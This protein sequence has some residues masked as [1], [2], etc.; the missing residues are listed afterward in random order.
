MYFFTLLLI[1]LTTVITTTTAAS[2]SSTSLTSILI[3]LYIYPTPKAWDS[4]YHVITA[5]PTQPFTII[6]NP[7]SGP[8]STR[9]PDE[10]YTE[11][12]LKLKKFKNVRLI[13]YVHVSY[14][15]RKVQDVWKDI[16][17]YVGWDA[18]KKGAI[19]LD[20]IFVDE[21]PEDVGT[22]DVKLKYMQMVRKRVLNGFRGIGKSG[23][24]M[25]NPGVIADRRF[26]G[27]TAD[28]VISF[29]DRLVNY[30]APGKLLTSKDMNKSPGAPSKMQAI[31]VTSVTVFAEEAG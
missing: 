30:Y 19:S 4:L 14:T 12:I 26:Y 10:S 8:G 23:F 3:P 31:I 24:T 20:G 27:L 5:Y 22:G 1:L 21:A 15:S 11:G 18:Y 16:D 6:V 7:D 28:A 17:K 2:S 13:G 9:F 29:E 25:I